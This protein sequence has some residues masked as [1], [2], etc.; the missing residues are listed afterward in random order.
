MRAGVPGVQLVWHSAHWRVYSVPGAPGIVS[1]PAR[2]LSSDGANV[3]LLVTRPGAV[4]VRERY[5]AAWRVASGRAVLSRARG[6][7][8]RIVAKAPGR[9]DLRIDL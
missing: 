5:V 6:G 3:R 1:G 2:L 7:W 8:L 4:I 9:V